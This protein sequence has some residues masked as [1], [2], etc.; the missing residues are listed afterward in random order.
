[1]TSTSSKKV[2]KLS[3]GTAGRPRITVPTDKELIRLG[4]EMVEWATEP[5]D[6][7]RAHITQWYSI[8]KE[9]PKNSFD[10]YITKPAFQDYYRRT[11]QALAV[12]YLDGTVNQSIAQ[13]FLRLYF[14]ELR[15]EEN[16]LL[17]LKADLQRRNEED[18]NA[19]LNELRKAIQEFKKVP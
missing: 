6:E 13:R 8:K 19:Q 15:E 11:I 5:T 17:Q 7:F 14:P 18:G 10:L 3:K 2:K 12:K 1:M 9:I 16:E 4:K